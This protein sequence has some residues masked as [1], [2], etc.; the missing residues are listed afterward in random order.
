[1]PPSVRLDG[2]QVNHVSE[3]WSDWGSSMSPGAYDMSQGRVIVDEH[4]GRVTV[5][6]HHPDGGLMMANVVAESGEVLYT[7]IARSH[8]YGRVEFVGG[9]PLG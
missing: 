8:L 5:E 7:M 1:M 4:T 3:A 6:L 2:V 9:E